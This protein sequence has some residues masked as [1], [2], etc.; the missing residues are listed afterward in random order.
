MQDADPCGQ[1][2]ASVHGCPGQQT[3]EIGCLT[4]SATLSGFESLAM[5]VGLDPVRMLQ[6]AK[7]PVAALNDPDILVSADAVAGLLDTSARLARQESFGLLLAETRQ[8]SNLGMLGLLVREEPTLRS[9]VQALG[10]FQRVQNG[11]LHLALEDDGLFARIRLDLALQKHGASRQGIEMAAAI[12]LHT[13]RSLSGGG[14]QAAW[15]S[16]VH[17]QPASLEVHRR[18]LGVR[19][20]FSHNA[21]AIVCRSRDLDRPVPAA[22]PAFSRAI[23]QCLERQLALET[24]VPLERVRQVIK[25]LLPGG[26]CSADQVAEHLGTHRRTLNRRLARSGRNVSSMIDEVRAELARGYL[27]GQRRPLYEIANLLGFASGAEFSRWFR[28]HFAMTASEWIAAS[29]PLAVR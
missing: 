12:T 9:A 3:P 19:V 8:L 16:F 11:A 1:H 26:A 29:S 17:A 27:A 15:I 21:N 10:R 20:E 18:V 6:A 28:D 25:S 7:L 4:R 23:R 14:F 24:E 5:S 13:L 22:N 2:S